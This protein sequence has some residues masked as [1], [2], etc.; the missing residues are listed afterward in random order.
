MSKLEIPYLKIVAQAHQTPDEIAVLQA[1]QPLTYAQLDRRSNQVANYLRT[2]GV[3]RNSRVGVITQRGPL[4]VIAILGILK[5]GGAYVPLD[6]AYPADRIRYILDHAEIQLLLSEHGVADTLTTCLAEPLQLRAMVLLDNG[7]PIELPQAIEQI[8]PDTWSIAATTAPLVDQDPDDLMTVLY[9][10]GSTGRPK[11]VMLNHQGYMNRLEWMQKAFQLRPGDRVAQKTSFCFDISVW[12]LFWTLMEGATICPVKREI[13]LNPWEFAQWMKTTRI[14]VMHFVP[15]LFG[16][17]INALVNES[18]D[19]PD[20]RWLIF[21]GEALPAAFIQQWIDQHG[22]ATGLANLYGPTEASID[23]TAHLI[24]SRPEGS[25]PI[26]KAIDNV[27]IRILDAEKRPVPQG[28]MGELW[29]GGVQLAKGYLKNPEKTAKTFQPNPFDDIP[30]DTLYRSGDLA[31][32]RPDGTFEYHG[33]IDHQVKIRGF[34]VELGEIENVLTQHP[35]VNESA[36]LAVDYEEGKKRLVAWLAG[37]TTSVREIKA[38]VAQKLPHYM[39]PQRIEW[40]PSLPKN[41]NGKLDRKALLAIQ[42]QPSTPSADNNIDSF[43]L[44]PAQRWI[45]NYFEPPYQ[46][47]GY[48][49]FRYQRALDAAQFTQAF[50]QVVVRHPALRTVFTQTNEQWQQKVLPPPADVNITFSDGSCFAPEQCDR[51]I[52]FKIQQAIERLRLDQWPLFNL[53]VM[54]VHETCYD[55][56]MVA[57]H[58]I[59]DLL[60]GNVLFQDLWATYEQLNHGPSPQ[61]DVET[62]Y[63]SYLQQLQAADQQGQLASHLDYWK[64]QFPTAAQSFKFPYDQL[65]RDSNIEGSAASELFQLSSATTETLLRDA[66]QRFQGNVYSLLLAPLYKL[67]ANWAQTEWV[68]ISHRSHGRDLGDNQVFWQSFG[69]FAVNVPLGLNIS[70]TDSWQTLVEKIGQQFTELPMNGITYDWIADRLPTHL[71]PDEKLTPIRAN[72]LGNRSLPDSDTFEFN[73]AERDRR[74]A[75]PEQKR[76]T[77]L[78]FFFSISEGTLQLEIEYSQNFHHAHTI[79]KLGQQYLDLIHALLSIPIDVAISHTKS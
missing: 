43:P 36:V 3:G 39:V 40:L 63:L 2:Q 67:M 37:Q 34:R 54:K 11:G 32:E 50:K 10:S 4:M 68:V 24:E 30:G 21:S 19:F 18:W 17:F 12:E 77:L 27:Y 79:Q 55:I 13:V 16:E 75:L 64:N 45:V 29:I 7:A 58:M 23:V 69:N 46:W 74:L 56:V 70:S 73:Q 51:Y 49:R 38:F 8:L 48:T 57:H 65:P 14:Q 62:T 52:E 61:T 72:Y 47:A 6:P 1:D 71:Y 78:E 31:K 59:A 15:S 53:L 26:G 25:I 28:E 42:A 60:A 22:M 33:R 9:T 66:K 44:A 35:S 41:H 20:L 5:A 76:T